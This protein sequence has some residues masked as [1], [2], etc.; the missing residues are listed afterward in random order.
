MHQ[1][2]LVE[3]AGKL[4]DLPLNLLAALRLVFSPRCAEDYYENDE[5]C[6]TPT[7]TPP[8][9]YMCLLTNER[10]RRT[11]R[12]CTDESHLLMMRSEWPIE[13]SQPTPRLLHGGSARIASPNAH[14]SFFLF[15]LFLFFFSNVSRPEGV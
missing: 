12:N 6:P 15:P 5:I 7:P 9:I 10:R 3:A 14:F 1:R 13:N 8:P 2:P 11:P 4:S